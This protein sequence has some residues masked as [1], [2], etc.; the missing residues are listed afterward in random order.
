MYKR[1]FR[2]SHG[3]SAEEA[4]V[5]LAGSHGDLLLVGERIDGS[6]GLVEADVSVSA[7]SEKLE[8]DSA[9]CDDLLIVL[10]CG[11]LILSL[12]HIYYEKLAGVERC[13]D[14]ELPFEIPDFWKWV[15]ITSI[16]ALVTKGTTPRG[17]NVAYSDIGVGFLRAENVAGLDQ[18]DL[19]KLNHIDEATHTGFLK[20]S[21]LE[22]D[23]V[24]ITIAGTLGR[25]C[26]LYT[27]RCV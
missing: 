12:I 14:D 24:L 7:D 20:R 25:T 3:V 13:I 10:C 15:R 17:G 21:I 27:S 1:Q 16:A 26:L 8:V 4:C 18:L 22:A 19:S 5:R 6:A 11:S 23:D 2:N 9:G